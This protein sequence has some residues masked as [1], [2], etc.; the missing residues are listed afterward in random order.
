MSLVLISEGN[1]AKQHNGE[2]NMKI[3]KTQKQALK[4]I[5]ENDKKKIRTTLA[6]QSDLD[7]FATLEEMK[8]V[9]V[10]HFP[11]GKPSVLITSR[12]IEAA[13]N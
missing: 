7:F 11:G 10:W 9:E 6:K 13:Q 3:T 12:G 8:L 1:D 4:I 5:I 2:R